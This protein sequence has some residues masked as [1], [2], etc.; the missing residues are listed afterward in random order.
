MG[1]FYGGSPQLYPAGAPNRLGG[2]RLQVDAAQ[3]RA[4]KN[5]RRD[6]SSRPR[7]REVG[8]YLRVESMGYASGLIGIT[9]PSLS[10]GG[11]VVLVYTVSVPLE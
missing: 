10:R 5:G 9:L 6:L 11:V 8:G 3:G 1:M 2:T 4:Q 7:S